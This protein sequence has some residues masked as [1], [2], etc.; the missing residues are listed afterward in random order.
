MSSGFKA[1]G[2]HPDLYAFVDRG[3]G[4]CRASKKLGA[5]LP[6]TAWTTAKELLLMPGGAGLRLPLLPPLRGA[7]ARCLS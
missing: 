1:T 3:L 6:S 5:G 7:A 4:S 2:T